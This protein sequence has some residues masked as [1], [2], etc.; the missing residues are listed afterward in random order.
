MMREIEE[1][2]RA[3][4]EARAHSDSMERKDAQDAL[5]R[6]LVDKRYLTL[7]GLQKVLDAD[8]AQACREHGRA[9]D[10]LQALLANL[11]SAQKRLDVDLG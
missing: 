2:L 3:V 1:A 4:D 5:A 7:T 11:H 8:H 10:E 9:M 6:L